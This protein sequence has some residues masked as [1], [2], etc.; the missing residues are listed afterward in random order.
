M[1]QVSPNGIDGPEAAT[2][3]PTTRRTTPEACVGS[4]LSSAAW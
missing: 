2:V 3:S 4:Q 1:A